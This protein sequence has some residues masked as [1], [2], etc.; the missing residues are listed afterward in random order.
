[1]S[2]PNSWIYLF[3][4]HGLCYSN[5]GNGPNSREKVVPEWGG[6]A[7][8]I[9]WHRC[10]A[11]CAYR[12]TDC[13]WSPSSRSQLRSLEAHEPFEK[14]WY[15][16]HLGNSGLGESVVVRSGFSNRMVENCCPAHHLTNGSFFLMGTHSLHSWHLLVLICIHFFY[17]TLCIYY[18][19]KTPL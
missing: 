6:C 12:L 1:M 3:N 19:R 14:F 8:A 18:Q 10:G 17:F 11:G 15:N 13:S 9:I 4:L 7:T 16:Q 5:K 2:I